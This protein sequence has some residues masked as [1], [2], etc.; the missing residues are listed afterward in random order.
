MYTLNESFRE[1]RLLDEALAPMTLKQLGLDKSEGIITMSI[2]ALAIHAF[3]SMHFNKVSAVAV[4]DTDGKLLGNLS[5]SDIRVCL[6][7]DLIYILQ[8]IGS[9]ER[10]FSSLLLPIGEFT[11]L[12]GPEFSNSAIGCKAD[13]T[14]SEVVSLLTA[15]KIHRVWVVENDK[16]VG[17]VSTTDI[18]RVLTRLEPVLP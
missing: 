13:T 11:Q 6:F 7:F 14:F 3:W 9:T 12:D 5:A 16:P 1:E 18:M 15:K 2:N 4:V 17:L 8:G 10:R